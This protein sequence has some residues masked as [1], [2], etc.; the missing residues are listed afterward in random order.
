M[1][2]LDA[3]LAGV[4]K[5]PGVAGAALVDSVTGLSYV[6]QGETGPFQDAHEI[7][8]L[9]DTRLRQAGFEGDLESVVVTTPS[10]HHV[11]MCVGEQGDALLL[12]A[13]VD[14]RRTNLAWALQDLARHA[15]TL[16]A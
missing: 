4:L 11:S 9:A 2:S 15:D 14:R 1:A 8:G 5:T 10:A 7:A 6:E 13:S 16:L 3:A 12:C